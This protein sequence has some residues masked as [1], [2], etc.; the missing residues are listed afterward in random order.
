MREALAKL[1]GDPKKI[2]PL[3]PV[4]LV[5]DHSVM[6]DNYGSGDS[7]K[8]TVAME[9]ERNGERYAFLRWG[10]TAFANFRV[11]PPGPGICPQVNLEYLPQ[12]VWTKEEG[13]KT[14]ASPDTLAL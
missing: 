14:L 8:K 4:D 12:V 5:I 2:N 9:F 10:P 3:S 13:G 11:V 7:F 1:G 6:V